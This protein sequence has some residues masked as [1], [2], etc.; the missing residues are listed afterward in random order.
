MT[1]YDDTAAPPG[2]SPE[3]RR[4]LSDPAAAGRSAGLWLPGDPQE[5]SPE[6]NQQDP[7]KDRFP[8]L[9]WQQAFA[10]DFSVIDWL[11]GRFMERGQQVAIVG[12][13]KVGK[14][15]FAHDWLWRAVTGRS[16]LG[17]ERHDPLRVLYFDRE[18]GLR[19]VVT[20]MQALGATPAELAGRFDY[21]MFPKFS[22]GLDAVPTAVAE[23]MSIVDET[24]PDIVIFDTVSRFIAGK[25]NESDTWLQFYG[26]VHAPLKDRC[27]ACARL[28]HMGKDSERGSRGSSAKS[29]DVDH[30]WEMTRLT[31]DHAR[32]GDVETVVTQIKMKRTHTRTGLGDD[33]L[34][35]TRRGRKGPSGM[36][37]P[38][39]TR[40]ELSDPG[41]VRQHA[42]QIQH[43]VDQL[44]KMGVPPHLGRD[45]MKEWA[46]ER[47][48]NLPGKDATLSEITRAV[49]ATLR[50][51]GR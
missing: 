26:R 15:L 8:S 34:H 33:L 36:W 27:I 20:R 25:E 11:P 3:V 31:E 12:D 23:L 17:D 29:Q 13:G 24:Q 44:V 1:T 51:D 48:L 41:T 45:R 42:Q 2:Y 18:N 32:E 46:A 4:I 28:D 6:P 39:E 50:G 49:K 35:I 43:F 40:H 30:V 38:G 21:R 37:L 47:G 19:D 14:T 10:T 16:F 5:D 22:G 7:G 9:D